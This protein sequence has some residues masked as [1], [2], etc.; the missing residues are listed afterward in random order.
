[1]RKDELALD[2]LALDVVKGEEPRIKKNNLN[3]GVMVVN[4]AHVKVIGDDR[5]LRWA[6]GHLLD[7]S[8]NYTLKGGFITI[9]IG[10]VKGDKVLLEVIDN[11][12]GIS[13][14][15]LPH[16]FERFYRGEARTASGKTIDPRG[17]GQG[18]FVARAVAEA[19]GGYLVASSTAGQG[20][21]FTLGLPIVK[22]S[23][24]TQ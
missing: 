2:E 20:S 17:L 5:R 6:I 9:R 12:V 10:L 24:L 11:G 16:I 1:V 4:R 21:K 7:N 18:L 14:K 19:H 8:I 15:D 3:V 23:E 22:Q 13:E